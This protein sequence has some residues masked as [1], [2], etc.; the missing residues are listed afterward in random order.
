[1]DDI[2]VVDVMDASGD[3]REYMKSVRLWQFINGVRLKVVEEVTSTYELCHKVSE[4]FMLELFD[5]VHNMVALLDG[6]HG[7]TL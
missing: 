5:E 3:L 2:K 1:M 4:L 7:I 6:K